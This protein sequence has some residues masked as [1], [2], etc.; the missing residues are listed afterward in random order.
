MKDLFI[1]AALLSLLLGLA[2]WNAHAIKEDVEPWCATLAEASEAAARGDWEAAEREV[3]ATHESWDAKHPYFHI[4]TAHDELDQ[5]DAL[6]AAAESFA[7]ER[8]AAEFRAEIAELIVQLRVVAEMQKL[9]VRN[10][11]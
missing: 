2:L 4:V 11:L 3:L 9:T 8:E 1:P 10:V 7:Q 5:A 6:F